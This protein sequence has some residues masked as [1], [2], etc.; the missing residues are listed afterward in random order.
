MPGPT[1]EDAQLIVQLAQWGTS[2][3]IQDALPELL[4]DDFDPEQ[5]DARDSDAVRRV[6]MYGES[7]AVLVHHDLLNRELVNDWLWLEGIWS[8]VGPAALRLREQVGEPRLYE[9]LEA[10]ATG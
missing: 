7:I 8:R 5:V 6:L 3:G 1:Q 2:L 10:L 4:A 9:H